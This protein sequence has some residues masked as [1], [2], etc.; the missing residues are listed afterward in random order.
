MIGKTQHQHF[1]CF[2]VCLVCRDHAFA[3]R[4][5]RDPAVS[6]SQQNGFGGAWRCLV[7]PSLYH[8]KVSSSSLILAGCLSFVFGVQD[9]RSVNAI[10]QLLGVESHQ[11][12]VAAHPICALTKEGIEGAVNWLIDAV[13]SSDRYYEKAT[14]G[15]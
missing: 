1:C 11:G 2:F 4:A 7:S 9:A 13:K 3:S 15:T 8:S 14:A 10:S 6:T 5:A 12:A